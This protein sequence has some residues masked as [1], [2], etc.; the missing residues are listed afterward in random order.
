ME[1]RTIGNIAITNAIL[2]NF[3]LL[4]IDVLAIDLYNKL[5]NT[6][7]KRKFWSNIVKEGELVGFTPYSEFEFIVGDKRLYRIKLNDISIKYEH[8]GTEKLY[9]TSWL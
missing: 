5:L 2:L 3:T 9:N 4:N 7:E 8:K 1:L 6:A